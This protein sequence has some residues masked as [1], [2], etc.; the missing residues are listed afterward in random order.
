[1][2]RWKRSEARWDDWDGELPDFDQQKTPKRFKE[3]IND[4]LVSFIKCI[5]LS[6]CIVFS[7]TMFPL[8]VEWLRSPWRASALRPGAGPFVGSLAGGCAAQGQHP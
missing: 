3:S 5:V 7:A 4:F 2:F 1:M 8:E 6:C